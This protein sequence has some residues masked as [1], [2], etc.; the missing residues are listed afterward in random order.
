VQKHV[1]RT[2][3][4]RGA[5]PNLAAVAD[6][7]NLSKMAPKRMFDRHSEYIAS[8]GKQDLLH[9]IRSSTLDETPRQVLLAEIAPYQ[10]VA[11]RL[12][13][14]TASESGADPGTA[15]YN[16]CARDPQTTSQGP[17]PGL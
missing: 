13:A 3:L 12:C 7:F 4:D 17:F 14:E 16:A 11:H 10:G 15:Y 2:Y 5:A 1:T 8:I 6:H 9:L